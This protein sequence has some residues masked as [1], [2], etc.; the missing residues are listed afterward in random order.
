VHHLPDEVMAG[1]PAALAETFEVERLELAGA[2][3]AEAGGAP[4]A[5]R[6]AAAQTAIAGFLEGHQHGAFGLWGPTLDAAYGLHLA[7]VSRAHVSTAH[8]PA[9]QELDVAILQALVL[10]KALGISPADIA[11]GKHVTYFKETSEAFSRL[12]AGEFQLGFFMNP[13][14][15]SQVCEVAFAG[16]RMPQKTTFFYPKLPT[17]L[18]FH[19]LSGAL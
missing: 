19:D 14:G 4:G 15:L 10:E 5:V 1:L 13:T 17:G 6:A 7:D 16:E 9:Y 18:L 12:Q 11:S 8:S 2:G 3:G